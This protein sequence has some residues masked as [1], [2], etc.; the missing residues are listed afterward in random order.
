MIR[1]HGTAVLAVI[2]ML[3]A[4]AAPRAAAP[5]DDVGVV[6]RV[7]AEARAVHQDRVRALAARSAVLF[8]DLLQTGAAA[9]LLTR[10]AD[11][12]E[13]TLGENAELRIDSFVYDPDAGVAE[14]ALSVAKGAFV[15]VGGEAERFDDARIQI[16]T[17]VAVLAIRGTTV[18]GGPIDGA[19]G[20]LALE[21]TV[22]VTTETGAVTITSITS[23]NQKSSGATMTKIQRQ[24]S[25]SQSG[26]GS[27]GTSSTLNI[28]PSRFRAA[29]QVRSSLTATNS[30]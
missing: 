7:Q 21:G 25:A 28:S 19:Y 13:I 20:V 5:G 8:E 29:S 12:S 24:Y 18:W 16:A 23:P 6:T 14:L 26:S 1:R 10:L 15:F 9:R 22:T 17:P 11:G 27:S 2:L 30:I 3:A 4:V